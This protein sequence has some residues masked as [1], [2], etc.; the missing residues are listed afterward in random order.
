MD[1]KVKELYLAH[2]GIL[3][4]KWGVRRYQ[5]ED[6]TYTEE[7]KLRYSKN[8]DGAPRNE[9]KGKDAKDLSDKELRD[10]ISRLQLEKAYTQLFET[11]KVKNDSSQ[12]QQKQK[13]KGEGVLKKIFFATAVTAMANIM[14]DKYKDKF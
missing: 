4:Q 12:K 7:G 10:R 5:N 14:Q 9:W 2:H 6:R 1:E 8:Y 11:P 13:K 3:G